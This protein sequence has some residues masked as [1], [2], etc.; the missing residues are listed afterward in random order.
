MLKCLQVVCAKYYE[1]RCMFKKIAI[2][3][4]LKID[5][6]LNKA[7]KFALFLVFSLKDE[8]LIKSKPT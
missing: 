1:P 6:L 4:K 3:S 7:S 2:S 8:K 5:V